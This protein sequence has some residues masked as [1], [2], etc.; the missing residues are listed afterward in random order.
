M[1]ED[2]RFGAVAGH[3]GVA[4]ADD[5]GFFAAAPAA[6]PVAGGAAMPSA[7]PSGTPPPFGTPAP[8]G[9]PVP[10]PPA[11]VAA[12]SGLPPWAILLITVGAMLVVGIVAA[13]ALP[14][15]RSDRQHTRLA[16]TTLAMPPA[17]TDRRLIIMVSTRSIRRS[18]CPSP[19]RG[20]RPSATA[21][22]R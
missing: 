17:R 12:P 1:A 8:F 5:Y 2:A 18:P 22:P 7:A 15:F 20:P 19:I 11:A 16:D 21:S 3:S 6:A 4:P 14:A 9:G 13:V 10:P